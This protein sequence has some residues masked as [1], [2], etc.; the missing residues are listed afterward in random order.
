MF[1]LVLRS[2]LSMSCSC[3]LREEFTILPCFYF[4]SVELEFWLSGRRV[5][6]RGF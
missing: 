6:L 2:S 3:E 1:S 4:C 5:L